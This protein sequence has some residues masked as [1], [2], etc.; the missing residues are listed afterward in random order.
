MKQFS[1]F[2]SIFF[3]HLIYWCSFLM[4]RTNRLWVVIGWHTNKERELF[5]DN[6]KYFFLHVHENETPI[7]VIWLSRDKYLAQILTRRGYEAYCIHS[8]RGAFYALRAGHTI[9][10][11]YL[12]NRF[13]KYTGG[14]KIIQLWHGKGMKKTGYDSSYGTKSRSRF[15]QPGFFAPLHTLIAASPYTAKLMQ[16]TFNVSSEKIIEVGLPR[17]DVFFQTITGSDIDAH[18]QLFQDLDTLHTLNRKKIF[19]YA[20][21]FR[22]D[23]SNPLNALNMERLEAVLADQN[24]H[25]IISLHPKFARITHD[26]KISF[27]HITYS[28]SGWD[29]YPYLNKVDVLITDYSSIYVDFLLLNK[30]IIFFTYDF[31]SYSEQMGLHEDYLALTPGPH[32]KTFEELLKTIQE[33]DTYEV[34]RAQ[35]KNILFTH[36]DGNASERIFTALTENL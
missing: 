18:P 22:P 28:E 7:R 25:V 32:P 1:T 36:H 4:P 26:T 2:I 8:I 29:S 19:L 35:V 31:E 15:L 16:S 20:P 33:H 6:A 14:S 27:E 11:A 34:E 23:G 5:A 10:D 21:T 3:A 17:D 12:E 30:P 24:Y 9:I 13:W